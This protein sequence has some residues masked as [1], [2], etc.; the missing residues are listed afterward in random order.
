M[1]VTTMM[2]EMT[3]VFPRVISSFVSPPSPLLLGACSGAPKRLRYRVAV[4]FVTKS[5]NS[6]DADQRAGLSAA[7][8]SWAIRKLPPRW[9]YADVSGPPAIVVPMSSSAR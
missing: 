7:M 1:F 5:K 4:S 8:V 6:P 3:M 9:V 2:I